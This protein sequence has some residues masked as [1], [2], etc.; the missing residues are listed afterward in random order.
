M[1]KNL[2]Q[3]EL[4]IIV[5][6]MYL[7]KYSRNEL[8]IKYGDL[9]HEYYILDKGQVEVIVYKDKTDPNDPDLRKKI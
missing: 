3:Y 4:K 8:I 7:K 9:G 6:A 5:D 2:T 1:T